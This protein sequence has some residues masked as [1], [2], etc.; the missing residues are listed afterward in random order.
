MPGGPAPNVRMAR[1]DRQIT[2]ARFAHPAFETVRPALIRLGT[3]TTVPSV[4][5]LDACLSGVAGVRF[6]T[7]RQGGLPYNTSIDVNGAVP[8]RANDWH[9][10][11]NALV[12]A[13]FPKAKRALHA[14]QRRLVEQR[15]GGPHRTREEDTLSIIDE[16]ALVACIDGP[17]VFGHAIYEALALGT[18]VVTP[19]AVQLSVSFDAAVVDAELERCLRDAERFKAPAELVH[20]RTFGLHLTERCVLALFA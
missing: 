4:E 9:D 7:Q 18:E 16:A 2:P 8:T 1:A 5:Q 6:V 19:R 11:M 10:F 20:V 12:W 3:L 15:A 13:T 17:R 14:R